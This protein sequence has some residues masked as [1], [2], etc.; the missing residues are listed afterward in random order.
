MIKILVDSSSDID[1]EEA[2]KLGVE[3]IPM[4]VLIDGVVYH[5][6]IDLSHEEFFRLL[7]EC[8][9]FPQTSQIS[10]YRYR[11]KFEELT[12]NGDSVIVICLSSG[13]SSTY[14]Q[15]VL[16]S[17]DFENVYVVDSLTASI[18]E[19]ILIKYAL[20]LVKKGLDVETI[21]EKLNEKK[22]RI[23]VF[24]L[25]GTLKYLKKGGRISTLVALAGTMLNIKPVICFE[26]GVV[27]F[28]GKTIGFKKGINLLK[29]LVKKT[30][31][32]DLDMPYT[33]GYSCSDKETLDNFVDEC[34][35]LWNGDNNVSKRMIGSTIGSHIGPGAVA[36]TYFENEAK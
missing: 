12:K 31:G 10:E 28:A 17:K 8:H 26:N 20:R 19:I 3:L 27:K 35:D 18:G 2:K 21:V 5:D 14:N 9:S 25:M 23:R 6:G 11:E 24:A 29:D 32:L 22:K 1:F 4:E 36:I 15:A 16:A 33:V 30:S 7:G 13:L 34:K